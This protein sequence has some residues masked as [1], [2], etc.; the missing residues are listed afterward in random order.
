[1]RDSVGDGAIKKMPQ[2]RL[3]AF[4]GN[5]S[6]YSRVTNNPE[7]LKRVMEVDEVS[8]SL[9]ELHQEAEDEWKAAARQEKIGGKQC[10]QWKQQTLQL[11]LDKNATTA[12][13]ACNG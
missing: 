6:S 3:E 8:M 7:H 13:F 12:F 10:E 2:R 11:E 4:S 5:I 1:M 9:G